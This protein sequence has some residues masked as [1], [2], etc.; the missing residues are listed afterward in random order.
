MK[1]KLMASC[2]AASGVLCLALAGRQ[3]HDETVYAQGLTPSTLTT[4]TWENGRLRAAQHRQELVIMA[5]PETRAFIEALDTAVEAQDEPALE[6]LNQTFQSLETEL[7]TTYAYEVQQVSTLVEEHIEKER[8]EA[9]EAK[10]KAEAA[11]KAKAAAKK[12]A[13]EKKAREQ[14]K[15]AEAERLK[16]EEAAAVTEKQA[17]E[18]T[19]IHQTTAPT[20]VA[21]VTPVVTANTIDILGTV[22]PLVDCQGAGA[23]PEGYLGGYWQ[24]SGD[25]N[26]GS[27]THIIGHNPGAFSVILS[28]G[29]GSPVTVTDGNGNSRTYTV[30]SVMDVNDQGYDRS[31]NAQWESILAQGGESISLQTCLGDYW[32]RMILAN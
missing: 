16:A 10:Q 19:V 32:N 7:Q 24:G 26:D 2:L 29:V 20:P 21:P 6:K 25:V 13:E 3:D 27:S 12:A 11:A 14:A 22:I 5:E 31:G 23:A 1:K 15:A 18:T 30:Y 28:L 4:E 9:A 17:E 8:Q